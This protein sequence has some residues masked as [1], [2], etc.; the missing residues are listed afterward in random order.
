MKLVQC[1]IAA[2]A[3]CCVTAAE[4]RNVY[5][6]IA[7]DSIMSSSSRKPRVG[8]GQAM[9]LY[10]NPGYEIVNRALSGWSTSQFRTGGPYGWNYLVKY[11]KPGDFLLIHFGHNNRYKK[12]PDLA[13]VDD[14]TFFVREGRK[15]GA[16]VVLLTPV[17]EWVF[18]NGEF[19]GGKE[20]KKFSELVQDVA[21]AEKVPVIDLNKMSEELFTKLG[22]EESLKLFIP[23]DNS[24]FNLDGAKMISE[25]LIRDA[26][27]QKLKL[28]AAFKTVQ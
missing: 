6:H 10:V 7:G 19:V 14:L 21:D 16:E 2:A 8:V 5:V 28:A 9:A 4:A 24:H 17:E 26:A 27:K 23:K 11:V 3:V 18:K 22:A 15:L 1:L 13:Y 12:L 20:L 25:M